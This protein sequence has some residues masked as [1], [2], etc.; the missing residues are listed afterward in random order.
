M[1][2]WKSSRGKKK[3]KYCVSQLSGKVEGMG[4]RRR[5]T[6]KI[7]CRMREQIGGAESVELKKRA[8][9]TVMDKDS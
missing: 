5:G 4:S 8:A 7:R 2:S 1:E 3:A 9:E 6:E